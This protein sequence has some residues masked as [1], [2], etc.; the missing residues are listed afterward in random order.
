MYNSCT[1]QYV[2]TYL[3]Y[4]SCVYLLIYHILLTFLSCFDKIL[5][6][7]IFIYWFIILKKKIP[8][9]KMKS[10]RI[11]PWQKYNFKVGMNFEFVFFVSPNFCMQKKLIVHV[12]PSMQLLKSEYNMTCQPK[13]FP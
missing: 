1:Y 4:L 10:I 7:M 5:F 12:E 8:A 13:F 3:S 2:S 11:F 9:L 6:I